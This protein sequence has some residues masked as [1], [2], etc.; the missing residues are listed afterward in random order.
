MSKK[1]EDLVDK[2]KEWERD[3]RSRYA[4]LSREQKRDY[5]YV[6]GDQWVKK[7][8]SK[9]EKDIK[10]P[11]LTFNELGMN[12]RWMCGSQIIN[13]YGMGVSGVEGGDRFVASIMGDALSYVMRR[14]NG[15]NI[16]SEIFKDGI[17]SGWGWLEGYIDYAEDLIDGVIKIKK[18]LYNE[19]WIDPDFREYSLQDANYI[20]IG[21]KQTRERIIES[22]PDV[23][24]SR[25]D[26]AIAS[27]KEVDEETSGITENPDND[28]STTDYGKHDPWID[29]PT[30]LNEP[31]KDKRYTVTTAWYWKHERQY[32]IVRADDTIE[33]SD[34]K[35]KN[36]KELEKSGAKILTQINRIPVY[37]VKLGNRILVKE[38]VSPLY[39]KYKLWPLVPFFAELNDGAETMELKHRGIVRDGRD[40]QTEINY[41]ATQAVHLMLS[42]SNAP[43]KAP[44]DT[45]DWAPD[46][47]QRWADLANEG[48]SPN[49]VLVYNAKSQVPIREYPQA[50]AGAHHDRVVKEN[51][52]R[53]KKVMGINADAMSLEDRKDISGRA[54]MVRERLANVTA[55]PFIQK[56]MQWT[57]NMLGQLIVGL[58]LNAYSTEKL[59]RIVGEDKFL[60]ELDE[61]EHEPEGGYEFYKDELGQAN[62]NAVEHLAQW[63]LDQ[64]DMSNYDIEISP[65]PSSPIMRFAYSELLLSMVAVPGN[66]NGFIPPPL[67]WDILIENSPIPQAEEIAKRLKD[68][69]K[70]T[71]QPP[72][73]PPLPGPT[74]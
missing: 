64:Y 4:P 46:K 52:D 53:L 15:E 60:K 38:T 63:V 66:P 32:Y 24:E 2:V 27:Y 28:T 12:V 7:V 69:Q 40:P 36:K 72:T 61:K 23:S 58:I 6:M 43:W 1:E 56:N 3:C 37:C 10:I 74:Q 59:V 21:R 73:Q 33:V 55:A 48:A 30:G 19:V 5:A 47:E 41:R 45:F 39:P 22:Y 71:G 57:Q 62:P 54:L 50:G 26:S 14:N 25:I 16:L 34:K 31:R 18:L 49:Y 17:I 35:P 67:V 29:S 11:A 42:A 51:E 20:L 8:K 68:L 13:R 65:I 44:H 70:Q 9:I